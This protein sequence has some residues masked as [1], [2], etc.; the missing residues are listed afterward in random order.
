[1]AEVCLS[2][3]PL[4]RKKCREFFQ[5]FS[6]AL[7]LCHNMQALWR[8]PNIGFEKY[9]PSLLTVTWMS[10]EAVP[11]QFVPMQEYRAVSSTAELRRARAPL[12]SKTVLPSGMT[13]WPFFFQHRAGKGA[14]SKVQ[15]NITVAPCTAYVSPLP[16][17]M[18]GPSVGITL[19]RVG[20]LF[21]KSLM[22]ELQVSM[23][24]TWPLCWSSSI[25]HYRISEINIGTHTKCML[26]YHVSTNYPNKTHAHKS[27]KSFIIIMSSSLSTVQCCCRM[28]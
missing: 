4:W 2:A 6:K 15:C 17:I 21:K 19:C 27:A 20:W 18:I 28:W 24:N 23:S 12:F 3:L 7:A 11:N 22:A 1:M 26:H 14:P 8:I 5:E 10:F 9:V 16:S 25:Y 13:S